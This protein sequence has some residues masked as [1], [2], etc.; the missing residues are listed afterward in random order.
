VIAAGIIFYIGG[1][2]GLDHFEEMDLVGGREE[3][4]FS[5]VLLDLSP[6]IQAAF[7]TGFDA[8]Y[9]SGGFL[10]AGGKGSQELLVVFVII[11]RHSSGKGF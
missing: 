3:I 7:K 5:D 2:P 10:L 9:F 1:E 11:Q 6:M 4:L 8:F